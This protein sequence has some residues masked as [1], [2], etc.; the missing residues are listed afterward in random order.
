MMEDAELMRVLLKDCFEEKYLKCK[1]CDHVSNQASNL[2]THMKTHMER[3][4]KC[5]QCEYASHLAGA[6]KKH[7]K[8]YS[9]EKTHKCNQLLTLQTL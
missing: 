4:Y 9:G 5:G 1:H 7:A 3:S 2:K 6:L 8:I